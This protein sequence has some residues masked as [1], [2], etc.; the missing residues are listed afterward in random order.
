[1]FNKNLIKAARAP[2]VAVIITSGM[3]FGSA[4]AA[5]DESVGVAFPDKYMIRLGSYIVD[6]SDTTFS[7]SSD[8]GGLGTVIDYSRDLGGESR[9]TIPRIDAYYRFNP[10]HRIDFTAFSIDRRS[11]ERRVGK[12]CRSRWSP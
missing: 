8:F 12:E 2:M 6:G 3:L 7:V 1:M 5:D 10:R 4:A 9:V 11:E